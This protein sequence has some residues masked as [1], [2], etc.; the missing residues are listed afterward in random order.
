MAPFQ[1]NRITARVGGAAGLTILLALSGGVTPAL[2]AEDGPDHGWAAEIA[3]G[4]SLATGNTDRQA[5]DL[6]GKAQFR[7]ERREDRYKLLGDLARENGGITSER[8]EV[9]A[10][11]NYDISK[12]KFYII[13]FTEYRRDKFSGFLYEAEIGPGVGYRFVRTDKL[14]FAVEFSTGYRHGE[15]RGLGNDD[16]LLFA[17][18]TATVDYQFSE[19]AKL[20]NEALVTGDHQRVSV[21]NTVSVTSSLIRDLALR[22]SINARYS[23]DPPVAIKKVDTL[24]KVALVYAF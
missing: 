2:G 4:G 6:E 7:T 15:L 1:F 20:T 23:S 21:E 13:G 5:L 17:R 24:S 18:G 16:D 3:V 14:T 8:V 12:D 9:G 19:T 22:A 11:T 10:Q